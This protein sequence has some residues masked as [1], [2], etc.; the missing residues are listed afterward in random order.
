MTSIIDIS[1]WQIPGAINYDVLASQLS[2]AIVRVQY[3][4]NYEDK[5]YKTHITEL[6]KRGVSIAVYAWI[7]GVSIADMEKEATDFYNR[8][9]QFN[10]TFWWIDVEEQSMG[11]MRAGANAFKNR[12]KVLGANKVGAYIA[13][14]L[15]SQ[16]NI[17]V[18]Q[19][20]A[21]WIPAYGK[22][23]GVFNGVIPNFPCDLH[24]Y[25]QN[26]RLNGY[27]GNLDMNRLTGSKALEW[28]TGVN[29]IIDGANQIKII[30]LADDTRVNLVP[31]MQKRFSSVLIAEGIRGVGKG[32]IE[33]RNIP[34]QA[35]Y[36]TIYNSL[37]NDYKIPTS[38]IRK[39][40]SNTI[41]VFGLADDTQ[42]KL[43]PDFQ[44]RFSSMYLAN[45]IHG[46]ATQTIEINSIPDNSIN[47]IKKSIEQDFKIPSF[48]IK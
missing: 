18:G 19:F 4:S 40:D 30:G 25:T 10:P 31:Q 2:H 39:V 26:G 41:H 12:L 3:G 35:N 34:N 24:Q 32:L 8:A 17:D 29:P 13:N 28:F 46:N 44:K 48:Q 43:V 14:H 5:H 27:S 21:I 36:N 15:Y 23:T 38:Q 6:Q 16:F 47:Q 22:D 20:D 37:I 42:V 1:E 33:L 11:D 45:V 9:K 7:R